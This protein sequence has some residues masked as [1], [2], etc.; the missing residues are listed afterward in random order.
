MEVAGVSMSKKAAAKLEQHESPVGSFFFDQGG[1]VH[2]EYIPQSKTITKESSTM[3]RTTS[4][5]FAG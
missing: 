3:S 4:K 1:V 5:F 2:Y